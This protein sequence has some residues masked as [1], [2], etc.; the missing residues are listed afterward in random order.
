MPL[1]QVSAE[2]IPRLPQRPKLEAGFLSSTHL[3]NTTPHRWFL[4]F[5]VVVTWY[6][7]NAT[8]SM[9]VPSICCTS[10]MDSTV[11]SKRCLRVQQDHGIEMWCFFLFFS[12]DDSHWLRFVMQDFWNVK[13]ES[14]KMN[15]N[16]GN[17]CEFARILNANVWIF[18]SSA[19][20]TLPN[21]KEKNYAY[22]WLPLPWRFSSEIDIVGNDIVGKSWR[23]VHQITKSWDWDREFHHS[24]PKKGSLS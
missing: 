8:P 7:F 20:Q 14:L 3:Q 19:Y 21:F 13:N 10:W 18:E 23:H 11:I 1:M 5:H 2:W 15:A 16:G 17:L 24:I 9:P 22:A 12:D 4:L 6:Y